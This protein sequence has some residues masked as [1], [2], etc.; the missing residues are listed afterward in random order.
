MV[1]SRPSSKSTTA[2]GQIARRSSSRVTTSP[3]PFQEQREHPEWLLLKPDLRPVL[4]ELAGA[5]IDFE[6]AEPDGCPA[7]LLRDFHALSSSDPSL[8]RAR[9]QPNRFPTGQLVTKP[10][11]YSKDL[12]G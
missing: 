12:A 2:S 11:C 7:G 9:A 8:A 3:G 6:R 10:F 5:E 4:A 1:A